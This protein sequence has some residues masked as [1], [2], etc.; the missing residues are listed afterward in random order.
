V[1]IGDPGG[2]C[3]NATSACL[4]PILSATDSGETVP[5]G[6]TYTDSFNYSVGT[7]FSTPLV[8]AVAALALSV[9]PLMSP[10]EVK[11]LLQAT[12][13]PFPTPGS[14][15]SSGDVPQCVPPEYSLLGRP[16]DQ[17][18]CSCTTT[19]CGAGMLDAGAAL[20]A[21]MSGAVISLEGRPLEAASGNGGWRSSSVGA[22]PVLR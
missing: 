15:G 11:T 19:T 6:S 8:A 14:G 22:A 21:A 4:Y 2:N 7:S 9:R 10:E 20:R 3:V 5:V 18:E 17:M 1:A 13:R 16:V 12:A